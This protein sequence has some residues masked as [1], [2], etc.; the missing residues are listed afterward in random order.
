MLKS[1]IAIV[2]SYIAMFVLF[3]VVVIGCYI[4]LGSE[5]V[6]KPDSY[7]ISTLWLALT[8]LSRRKL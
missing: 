6:F 2:V 7:E 4:A 8:A 3:M 5:R 1:I